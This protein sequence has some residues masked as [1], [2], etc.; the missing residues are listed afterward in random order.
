M[1]DPRFFTNAGPFT[2]GELAD[3]LGGTLSDGAPRDFAVT[4]LATLDDAAASEIT[5]FADRRYL[6]AYHRTAAG[7]VLTNP[8]L[9]T[10][11]PNA[12]AH[13]I[14]VPQ[15]RH[16]LAEVGWLFYPRTAEAL[17]LDDD[18]RA[19]ALANGATV[20]DTA[21]IGRNSTIGARTIIGAG[22]VVTRDVPDDVVAA[23]NPC[24]VLRTNPPAP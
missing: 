3:R 12:G 18:G 6:D 22:S 20:A 19:A 11:R 1:I 23:G 17:G 8:E 15:P 24:R 7:A 13:L 14:I 9:A 2:L 10:S 4:D 21:R 5:L 16:A